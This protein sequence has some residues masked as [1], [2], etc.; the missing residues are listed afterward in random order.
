MNERNELD[1][2]L[3]IDIV[4]RAV[5]LLTHRIREFVPNVA[6]RIGLLSLVPLLFQ[7]QPNQKRQIVSSSSPGARSFESRKTHLMAHQALPPLRPSVPL[8]EVVLP[9]LPREHRRKI[10]EDDGVSILGTSV[11]PG[12]RT[13]EDELLRGR[14]GDG[15]EE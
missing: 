6:L 8:L 10:E 5:L 11:F 13:E 2:P 3:E 12:G 14:V 1:S 15:G 9:A 4:T 7:T